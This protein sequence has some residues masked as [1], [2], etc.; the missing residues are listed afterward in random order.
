MNLVFA[1]QFVVNLSFKAGSYNN[2]NVG[3]NSKYIPSQ[4]NNSKLY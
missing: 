4:N 3:N 1:K 2:G